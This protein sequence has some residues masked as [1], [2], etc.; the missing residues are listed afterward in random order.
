MFSKVSKAKQ[1][2]NGMRYCLQL[3]AKK[4]NAGGRRLMSKGH[5]PSDACSDLDL[6]RIDLDT[7]ESHPEG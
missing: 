4:S 5:G 7:G 2:D 1:E 6:W 3:Q